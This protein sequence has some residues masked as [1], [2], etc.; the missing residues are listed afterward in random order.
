MFIRIL[1]GFL[2]VLGVSGCATTQ[3]KA[4]QQDQ[5]QTRVVELEKKLEEKDA[6]IVDLQYAVKDLSS[7]VDASKAP[8]AAESSVPAGESAVAVKDGNNII[9]VAATPEKVQAA[10]KAAGFYNGRVDGKIG[11]GTK[12]AIVQFQRSQGLNADG[13]VGPKT[14]DVLKTYLQ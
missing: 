4:S 6:E 1:F 10:L 7:R 5:M 2:F 11:A 8:A 14:W 12:A 13:V 3:H 9:R